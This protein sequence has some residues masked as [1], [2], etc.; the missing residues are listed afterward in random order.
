MDNRIIDIIKSFDEISDWSVSETKIDQTELYLI[1]DE[2]ESTRIVKK[3]TYSIAL[4]IDKEESGIKKRGVGYITFSILLSDEEI[5]K[6]ISELIF[7]AS[8][9]LNPHFELAEKKGNEQKYIACDESIYHNPEEVIHQMKTEIFDAIAEEDDIR[10]SSAEIFITCSENEFQTSRGVNNQSKKT[11]I[12]LELVML[13]GGS[14]N[15]VE[16]SL[17]RRERFLDILDV[18]NLIKEYANHARNNLIAKL[19]KTGKYD[20]IFTGEALEEFFNY[21]ISQSAGSSIYYKTSNLKIGDEVI[22]GVVGEK[23]TMSTDPSLKGGINTVKYDSYGTLLEKYDIIENGKLTNI[24]ADMQYGTYIDV[25][26]R[27]HLSNIV[28]KNGNSAFEE[29]LTENTFVL[30][31]F[32]T[33]SPNGITG[34]FSGE[35]RSGFQM[36]DGKEVQIK[37]GSV[38]GLMNAAMKEV[39]FSKEII[40]MQNYLGPKYIKVCNLDIAGD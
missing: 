12:M 5:R 38:T 14:N 29:L 17:I 8:L 40:Q 36:K 25:V 34:A 39:Y 33:F 6:L 32:S 37:G 1:F 11:L 13:C 22:K 2:I 4:Y 35:I 19:P 15:E 30:S 31:R 16:S 20:V 26:P 21:Y 28:I 3:H 10:L 9:A 18:K 27:G 23:L 7:S 24:S